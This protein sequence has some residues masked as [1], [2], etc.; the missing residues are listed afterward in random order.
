MAR[1]F[2]PGFSDGANQLLA[3]AEPE[4]D[5]VLRDHESFA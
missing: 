4:V 3:S 5:P 2:D 1:G